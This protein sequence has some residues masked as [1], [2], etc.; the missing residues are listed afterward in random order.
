MPKEQR[1]KKSELIASVAAKACLA[2]VDAEAAVEAL[3]QTIEEAMKEDKTVRLSGFGTFCTALRPAR[4][5]RNPRTG[6]SVE[7]K[8][9]KVVK[10]KIGKTLKEK[11][12]SAKE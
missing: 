6:E 11:I 8:E 2:K 10:F 1:M 4:N 9:T 5:V 7:L 3:L 12:A